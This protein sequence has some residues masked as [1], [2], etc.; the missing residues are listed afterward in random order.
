MVF[1]GGEVG[2]VEVSPWLLYFDGSACSRGHGIGC[3]LV[4]P[5]GT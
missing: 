1:E 3:V 5:S 4:S 2:L